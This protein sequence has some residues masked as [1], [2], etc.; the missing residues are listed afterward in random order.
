VLW[1]D[2]ARISRYDMT[3]PVLGLAALHAYLRAGPAA[4][5]RWCFLAGLLAGL[6][7]LG[8]LYGAFW[9]PV[10]LILAVWDRRRGAEILAL[11]AGF[12][13]PWLV[14]AGYVLGDVYDW[15]GQTQGYANR[16]DLLNPWWYV[17][18]VLEE[19]QRYGPG[20][21]PEGPW[22]WLLRPAVWGALIAVPLSLAGLAWRALWRGERAARIL[23]VPLVLFPALFALLIRLKLSNYLVSFMPLVAL[24]VAWGAHELWRRAAANRGRWLR[25]ALAA[26]LVLV[27]VEGAT[28]VVVLEAAGRST[29]PYQTVAG[30]L[31][32]LLPPGGRVLALH[33]YWF[34][35]EDYDY[36]SFV[37]PL[38][39]SDGNS[40][41]S[42]MA[43]GDA[44]DR[45]DPD[46]VVI[47]PSM[48]DYFAG[49]AADD[50]K[51]AEFQ[52]WLERRGAWLAG[53]VDDPT[54]GLIEVYRIP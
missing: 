41:P 11:L 33:D 44:L 51:P 45:V 25:S 22:G 27:L 50:P 15:R 30:R 32:A 12:A 4:P 21:R 9:L 7:G 52:A 53:R 37:V 23:L 5:R 16:F 20:L 18:N 3:V 43:F 6:A 39:W 19:P 10:L 14:Y 29:T 1:L 31:R 35:L 47:E 8:H 13:L 34:G 54:Y 46:A 48:R 28:R 26:L 2:M 49:A 40:V 42:P 36:R 17:V 38:A 24:A